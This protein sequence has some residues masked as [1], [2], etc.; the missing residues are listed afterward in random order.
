MSKSDRTVTRSIRISER[1]LKAIEE[2]SKR[3][4]V[5]VNTIINQQ[6][7]S[8]AEFERFFKR[9]GVMKIS[10]STVQHLLDASSEVSL[11]KAGAE[12]GTHTPHSIIL[13]KHGKQTLDTVYDYLEILSEYANQFEFSKVEQDGSIVITLLH[14]LGPKGSIFYENYM[15]ALFE[16]INYF[17][18]IDVKDDS[19]VI[20]LLPKR[21]GSSD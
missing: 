16:Q 14:R 11:A 4:N 3:Q 21:I 12:T 1:A 15:K 9:L 5:S 6:L 17:P 18:K 20:E 7:L 10:S 19:V 13:A 2:E 8:Y